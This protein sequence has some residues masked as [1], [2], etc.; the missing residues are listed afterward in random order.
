MV[1][2]I[3]SVTNLLSQW[4]NGDKSSL[5]KLI[6]LIYKELHHIANRYL[7]REYPNH[8]LQATA[9]INEAFLRLVNQEVKWQNRAH[10]FGVAAELMRRILVDYARSQATAKRGSGKTKLSLNEA[11]DFTKKRDLDLLALNDALLNLAAIDEQQSRIVEL[12][13][14][15]GLTIEETAEVMGLSVAM[16]RREWALAK[17]WLYLA[18]KRD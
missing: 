6:P 5:D 3:E 15:G 4:S 16:V 2:K 14:F 10:F 12:R 7:L 11:I 1:N 18:I 9:L 13:F 17:A 8:T